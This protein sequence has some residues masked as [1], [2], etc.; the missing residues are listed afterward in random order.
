MAEVAPTI[1]ILFLLD[2]STS[3]QSARENGTY[4]WISIFQKLLET[5]VSSLE[6]FTGHTC[7]LCHIDTATS[8]SDN[9]IKPC[10]K[11]GS[12][13]SLIWKVQCQSCS[14][15]RKTHHTH[16]LSLGE[17]F[18]HRQ[19]RPPTKGRDLPEHSLDRIKR[20]TSGHHALVLKESTPSIYSVPFQQVI[21]RIEEWLIV[22][23]VTTSSYF[24][25]MVVKVVEQP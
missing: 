9:V 23:Y 16:S 3:H 20:D 1:T 10:E 17:C 4:A 6:K 8:L 11:I 13:L 19:K 12:T 5:R 2:N 18:Q 24:L 21:Q 7:I 15:T 14:L 22:N 25:Q